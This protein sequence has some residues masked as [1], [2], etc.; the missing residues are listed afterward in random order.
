MNHEKLKKL[1]EKRGLSQGELA[2]QLGIHR[3]YLN[4]I[5]RGKVTPGI[6]LLEKIAHFFGKGLKD[7]F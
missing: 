1:R 6:G 4:Q 5:E 3:T 2:N 7:F